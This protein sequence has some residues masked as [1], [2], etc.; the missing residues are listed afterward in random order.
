MDLV[1][2]GKFIAELRK[3]QDL[4]QQELGEILGV[5]NKTIS[6]WENG[7][8]MPPV[9]ML[10]MIGRRFDVTINELL[11]GDRISDAEYKQKAEENIVTA[12][13]SSSFS[14]KEKIDYWK[15]KWQR[16]HRLLIVGCGIVVIA[17][18][19]VGYL[20][21]YSFLMGGAALIAII[22]YLYCYNRMMA[23]VEDHA[24]DGK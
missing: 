21:H 2:I 3:E 9:E 7:N 18:F 11:S 22:E 14:L 16:E 1:K 13:S 24:F 17:V 5:T 4:T 20:G 12:L 19:A 6:R 8:Y 23:Y 15:K 10:Q